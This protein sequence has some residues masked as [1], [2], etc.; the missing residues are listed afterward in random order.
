MPLEARFFTEN[1][2]IKIGKS[3]DMGHRWTVS[4]SVSDCAEALIGAYY[5]SGGLTAALHMM[6]WLGF[7]VEFDRELVNEAIN[8]VSLRCYIP[9]DDELTELET[10]IR[11]EFS[12]KFLLKEAITHSSVHESYSYEVWLHSFNPA[13]F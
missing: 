5:V 1:M 8:R 6:K 10:K 4:K 12:S 9:K 2:T 13:F 3:C 11:R 7:D